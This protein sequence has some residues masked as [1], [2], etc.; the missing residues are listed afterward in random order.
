MTK[1]E[2]VKEVA[3]KADL[4]VIN[5]GTVVNA[6]FESIIEALQTNDEVALKGFGVF[7]TSYRKGREGKSPLD[8]SKL[9]IPD[10]MQARFKFSK[11]LL[12]TVKGNPLKK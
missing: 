8:G 9:V 5:A 1:T 12:K 6:V 10:Q 7:S 2:L 4:S 11:A 3:K